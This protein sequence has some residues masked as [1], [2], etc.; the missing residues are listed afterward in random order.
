MTLK[1]AKQLDLATNLM[2]G[3]LAYNHRFV[4]SGLTLSTLSLDVARQCQH[5]Y[6]S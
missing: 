6:C 1:V 2:S 5:G 4:Q 3:P